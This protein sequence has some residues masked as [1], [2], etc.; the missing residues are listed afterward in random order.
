LVCIT[1][2]LWEPLHGRTVLFTG[3]T[4]FIGRW[5]VE[6]LAVAADEFSFE[7]EVIHAGRRPVDADWIVSLQALGMRFRGLQADVLHRLPDIGRSAFL[8]HAAT[9]ASAKLNAED[10]GRMLDTIVQGTRN[11]L[12]WAGRGQV[13]RSLFLSSGAVYGGGVPGFDRPE[14]L[15]TGPDPLSPGSAYAEGKRVAEQLCAI[16]CQTGQVPHVSIARCFAFVGP[17]LPLDTH[18]AIGNF[19]R[20]GLQG[21]PFV[22][23][24]DGTAVRS[25]LYAGDLAIWL[26]TI[27]L[28]GGSLRPYNVGSHRGVTIRE[29]AD[30]VAS[31]FD[32]AGAIEVMG[33]RS[34]GPVDHYVPSTARARA[35]LGLEAWT[36]LEMAIDRTIDWYRSRTTRERR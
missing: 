5:M 3:G 2:Q 32:D 7:V 30:I 16:A 13:E 34:A 11:A 9:D 28:R 8:V 27:L 15:M 24:G 26:W 25:Y 18:F 36:S 4:G 23:R 29:L 12:E 33:A 22:I 35:E 10:P 20:D 21:R 17:L 19:I 6:T 1:P 31:R 14:D